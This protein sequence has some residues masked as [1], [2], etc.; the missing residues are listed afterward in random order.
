MKILLMLPSLFLLSGCVDLGDVGI[1]PEEETYYV[2]QGKNQVIDCQQCAASK[3][4]LSLELFFIR[5]ENI[6][7]TLFLNT[8]NT[9]VAWVEISN[10]NGRQTSVEFYY[11]PHA[12]DIH[13]S[14]TTI[15]ERCT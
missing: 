1:H 9:T 7:S 5:I 4:N 13:R 8:E 10:F 11:A 3:A 15:A 6:D 2:N 14:V 12:P